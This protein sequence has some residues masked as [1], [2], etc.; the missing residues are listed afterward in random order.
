ML[1]RVWEG[2]TGGSYVSV[3]NQNG[4]FIVPVVLKTR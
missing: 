3:W 1:Y 2:V 4:N